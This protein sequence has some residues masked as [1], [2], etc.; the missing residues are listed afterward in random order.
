MDTKKAT[1]QNTTKLHHRSGQARLHGG[2]PPASDLARHMVSINPGVKGEAWRADPQLSYRL[3]DIAGAL[4]RFDIVKDA[5]LKWYSSSAIAKRGFC[6]DCG[7]SLFYQLHA[8]SLI[9]IAPGMF[10][11]SD[12]FEVA[13]QIYA[14]SHPAWGPCDMRRLPPLDDMWNAQS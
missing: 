7:A 12:Q 3:A 5:G 10:D 13:G 9:A 2:Q 6:G 14:A 4:D 8:A 1:G 11:Q